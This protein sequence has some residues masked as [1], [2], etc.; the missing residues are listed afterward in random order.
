MSFISEIRKLEGQHIL[1]ATVTFLGAVG[2]GYLII[3]HYHPELMEKYDAIKLTLFAASLCVPFIL[4]STIGMAVV[5]ADPSPETLTWQFK[6][7]AFGAALSLYG[8]IFAAY[9]F[10]LNLINMYEVAG[11]F[12][13]FA[14]LAQYL[15]DR[16]EKKKR[17]TRAEGPAQ[18]GLPKEPGM[19][20]AP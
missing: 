4:V 6:V 10:K 2:P 1:A 20:P 18:A 9:R 15:N 11:A 7:G 19:P 3:Y 8:G 16:D 14:V 13:A 12:L 17:L 5:S